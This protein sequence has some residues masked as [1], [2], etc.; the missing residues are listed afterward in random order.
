MITVAAGHCDV[1]ASESRRSMADHQCHRIHLLHHDRHADDRPRQVTKAKLQSA[2]S[3]SNSLFSRAG[4]DAGPNPLHGLGHF[5]IFTPLIGCLHAPS[6]R[7]GGCL[8]LRFI[9]SAMKALRSAA[10]FEF[11]LFCPPPLPPLTAWSTIKPFPLASATHLSNF[12]LACAFAG[13]AFERQVNPSTAI[14]STFAFVIVVSPRCITAKPGQSA[15]IS[16]RRLHLEND[17]PGRARRD[18]PPDSCACAQAR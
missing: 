9:H 17:R 4:P 16:R 12:G 2:P 11:A 1:Y 8:Y 5:R 15:S 7:W 14:A 6:Y 13:P 18:A 3:S 10:K